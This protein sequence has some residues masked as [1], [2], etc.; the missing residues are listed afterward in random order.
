MRL[1]GVLIGSILKLVIILSLLLIVLT[2]ATS[3][4]TIRGVPKLGQIKTFSLCV[5][6][7]KDSYKKNLN[8]FP[9]LIDSHVTNYPININEKIHLLPLPPMTVKLSQ[10][11]LQTCL[12]KDSLKDYFKHLKTKNYKIETTMDGRKKI[13]VENVQVTLSIE[14]KPFGISS[15][16]VG[17]FSI[18]E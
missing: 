13:I 15:I 18:G 16:G 7:L 17:T 12:S 10:G 8:Y 3:F 9:A 5:Y 1:I 14:K 11:K 2:F 6:D 4:Y